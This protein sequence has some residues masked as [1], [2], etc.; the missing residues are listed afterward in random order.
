MNTKRRKLTVNISVLFFISI[1]LITSCNPNQNELERLQQENDSLRTSVQNTN[2]NISSYFSDLN[3]IENNLQIIKDKED[4]ITQQATRDVELGLSQ[5]DRINEDI[6]VIGDLM[7]KNR[8][9]IANL[10]NRIRNADS[11]IEGFEQM[12]ERL[13]QTIEEK[14]IEIQLLRDQLANMNLRVDFLSARVD[15]LERLAQ[16]R[17]EK[18][19]QQ[20]QT[21]NTAW[22][23]IGSAKELR[24]N[25]I[26]SREGG[27]LGLGRTDILNPELNQDFFTRID[28]TRDFKITIIG[29]DPKIITSHPSGSY[30]ITDEND[31]K[32]LEILDADLFWSTTR[33]LVVQVK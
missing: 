20:N 15:T 16:E 18:I 17:R 27:F 25:N 10:N 29:T 31:E 21:M 2:E 14:E 9:L 19:E 28:I 1:L 32:Y 4:L 22:Y 33:Y 7:E 30:V 26:I 12:V 8:L 3:E 24:E 23:A 13:N 11:R 5:Q 6:K